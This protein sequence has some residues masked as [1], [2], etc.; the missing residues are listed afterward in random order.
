M[1]DDSTL[2]DRGIWTVGKCT[3]SENGYVV[4]KVYLQSSDFTHDVILYV[5]GDFAS[6]EQCLNYAKQLAMRLNL[7]PTKLAE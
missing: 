3:K 7:N 4:T 1:L 2:D 6:T 5:N